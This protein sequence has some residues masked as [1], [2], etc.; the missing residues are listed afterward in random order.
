MCHERGGSIWHKW[1]RKATCRERPPEPNK[2][3]FTGASPPSL[4]DF[5]NRLRGV[6]CAHSLGWWGFSQ[7]PQRTLQH[8]ELFV[9]IASSVSVWVCVAH[10]PARLLSQTHTQCPSHSIAHSFKH[11]FIYQ[12]NNFL[13]QSL[14]HSFMLSFSHSSRC[15]YP[16][17]A[18]LKAW[19]RE[20]MSV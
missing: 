11:L 18:Y 9:W 1:S 13:T 17:Q 14:A 16:G 6:E 8:L 3:A 20:T 15:T 4:I 7:V 12:L 5:N 19:F 2:S 10:R